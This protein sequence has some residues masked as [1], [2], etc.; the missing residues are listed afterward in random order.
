MTERATNL[1]G[2]AG[3]VD[4]TSGISQFGCRGNRAAR[5]TA[6]RVDNHA[7]SLLRKVSAG[8]NLSARFD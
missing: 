6:A 1:L 3:I 8:A 4:S 7:L 2:A 5:Q